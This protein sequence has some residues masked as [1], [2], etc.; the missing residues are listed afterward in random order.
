M[1]KAYYGQSKNGKA[2]IFNDRIG[3][4]KM[5]QRSINWLRAIA[6]GLVVIL[7]AAFWTWVVVR[8]VDFAVSMKG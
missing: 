6:W 1:G 7:V 2:L 4:V 5:G 3:Y 8:I